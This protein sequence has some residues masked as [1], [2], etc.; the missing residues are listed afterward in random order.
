MIDLE[1]IKRGLEEKLKEQTARAEEI[2]DDLSQPGD[3]DGNENAIESEDDEVLEA[4]GDITLV[5]I[6]QVKNSLRQIDAGNYGICSK[7]GV[8]IARER[9]KALPDATTCV[10]CS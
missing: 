4:V 2:D 8:S 6:G 5:E 3:D 7:C 9:L 1:N 10:R